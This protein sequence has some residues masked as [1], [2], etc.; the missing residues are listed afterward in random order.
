MSDASDLYSEM[1]EV[2]EDADCAIHRLKCV[3][4]ILCMIHEAVPPLSKR[5]AGVIDDGYCSTTCATP[6]WPF[7]CC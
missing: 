4:A 5:A 7:A 1:G 6:A 2:H 3:D